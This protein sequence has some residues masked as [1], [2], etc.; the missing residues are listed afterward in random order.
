MQN[1]ILE[2]SIFKFDKT[3]LFAVICFLYILSIGLFLGVLKLYLSETFSILQ[4]IIAI[5]ILLL[6]VL[7]TLNK[8]KFYR[9]IT[10]QKYRLLRVEND[11]TIELFDN[12][13]N[14]IILPKNDIINNNIVIYKILLGKNSIGLKIGVVTFFDK[15]NNE[16]K[17]AISDIEEFIKHTIYNNI[18]KEKCV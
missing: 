11:G 10:S 12:K 9:F 18:V 1:T 2:F 14:K 13:D 6:I 4:G 16:Y 8:I 3:A 5:F 15:N 17:I 7:L